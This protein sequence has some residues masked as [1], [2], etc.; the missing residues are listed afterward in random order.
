LVSVSDVLSRTGSGTT[1][2]AGMRLA[3]TMI[4]DAVAL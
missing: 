2:N 4:P 3:C 1:E